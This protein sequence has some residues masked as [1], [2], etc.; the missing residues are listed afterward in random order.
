MPVDASIV[1][2]AAHTDTIAAVIQLKDYLGN[3]VAESCSVIAYLSSDSAGLN[4]ATAAPT[5]D[6][7]N[8]TDGEVEILLASHVYLLTSEAD[9]DIDVTLGYTTGA[10]DF[11]LVIVLPTGKK[12]VSTKFEFTA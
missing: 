3:D 10:H 6:L 2:G 9:G 1:V 7:A 8:G 12:I 5:T 11:F 4:A